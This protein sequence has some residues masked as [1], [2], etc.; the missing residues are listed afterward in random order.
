MDM[1]IYQ[2]GQDEPGGRG[3]LPL[4]AQYPAPPYPQADRV[5]TTSLHIHHPAL[6]LQHGTR[7]NVITISYRVHGII[8]DGRIEAS[9]EVS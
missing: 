1:S 3:R 8:I 4:D 5:D 2:A 9:F 6:K 7:G